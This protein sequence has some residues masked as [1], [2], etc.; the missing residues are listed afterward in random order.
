MNLRIDSDIHGLFD[1]LYD[2]QIYQGL[3]SDIAKNGILNKGIVVSIPKEFE[4]II[5]CGEKRYNISQ[6]LG[7]DFPY[8][9]R[10]F[11][12]KEEMVEFAKNDNLL[13]RNLEPFERLM[14]EERFIEW[15][16]TRPKGRPRLTEKDKKGANFGTVK[17]KKTNEVLAEKIGMGKE[18]VRK[19]RYVLENTSKKKQPEIAKKIKSKESSIN[20]EYNKIKKERE[21]KHKEKQKRLIKVS[22]F[23]SGVEWTDYGINI[24][25]G[26]KHD[27]SYCYG[28][29][30]NDRMKWVD[31]WTEPKIRNIDLKDLTKKLEQLDAGKIMFC[32]VT[33]PY[34]PINVESWAK[35][36]LTVLLNSKH[37]IIILTK[38]A[39]IE[40]DLDFL[41]QFKNVEVG[42]TITCL[43]DELNKKYEP[44]S[45]SPSERIRVIK[46]AHSMGIKTLV[47]IEPWIIG[48]TKPLEII[49][50]LE[51]HVDRWI[52]G[53]ANYMGFELEEYRPYVADL[54]SYL[55]S[56]NL[57]YRF[58]AE[59]VRVIKS[60][61]LLSKEE[62]KQS[63]QQHVGNK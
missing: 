62:Y 39:L 52:I 2:N 15:L 31:I 10:A 37:H 14:I 36:V 3:K 54:L 8:E 17:G 28:R 22:S 50:E 24:S 16:E 53:V 21:T 6:E 23:E 61:P 20:K 55:I 32:S 5:V 42:F 18:N 26:C 43:D 40:K 49:K 25:Y 19:A 41:S 4:G 13:R 27:C 1:G 44:E 51:N 60:Y 59:L 35:E 9:L 47:S 58:K 11:E 12:N 33:D 30:M 45:S 38:S 34:Q 56:R 48:H 46:K 63:A 7:I 29:L 57:K